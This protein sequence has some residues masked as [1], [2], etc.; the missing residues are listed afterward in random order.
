VKKVI[1]IATAIIVVLCAGCASRKESISESDFISIVEQAGSEIQ[2]VTAGYEGSPLVEKSIA[3]IKD[4]VQIELI[5]TTSDSA[6]ENVY[7]Q[8]KTRDE[9]SSSGSSTSSSMGNRSRYTI[10]T[11]S[12]YY[13]C[14]RIGKT[15]LYAN[16]PK[17]NKDTIQ[18]IVNELGY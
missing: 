5:I 9:Q 8:T 3:A 11:S 18:E 14:S 17:E 1:S 15:V 12:T 10:T 4:G 6:G 2:D 7:N 16:E 13:F